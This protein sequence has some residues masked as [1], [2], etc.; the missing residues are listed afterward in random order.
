M[1]RTMIKYDNPYDLYYVIITVPDYFGHPHVVFEL[2]GLSPLERF[3]SEKD[4]TKQ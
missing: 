3:S 2:I 4:T 1:V